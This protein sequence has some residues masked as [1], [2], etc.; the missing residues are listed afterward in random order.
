MGK[1]SRDESRSGR[2]CDKSNRSPDDWK[3]SPFA[4]LGKML[5]NKTDHD[6][7]ET[8]SPSTVRRLPLGQPQEAYSVQQEKLSQERELKRLNDIAASTISHPCEA[9][10]GQASETVSRYVKAE[11]CLKS[12]VTSLAQRAKSLVE[13][14]VQGLAFCERKMPV[15]G[16]NDALVK[17]MHHM[18]EERGNAV[19]LLQSAGLL[20]WVR[21]TDPGMSMAKAWRSDACEI[22]FFSPSWVC[23]KLQWLFLMCGIKLIDVGVRFE[24]TGRERIA[25]QP[26]KPSAGKQGSKPFAENRHEMAVSGQDKEKNPSPV[27]VHVSRRA[28]SSRSHYVSVPAEGKTGELDSYSI[29]LRERCSDS[30]SVQQTNERA[31]LILQDPVKSYKEQSGRTVDQYRKYCEEKS[32]SGSRVSSLAQRAETLAGLRVHG[33]AFRCHEMLVTDWCDAL[34][35]FMQHIGWEYEELVDRMQAAGFLSWI[36]RTDS[37]RSMAEAWRVGAC[38]IRFDT[39][40]HV[41]EKLQWLF[42]MCGMP[43]NDVGM[44]YEG[45]LIVRET[46]RSHSRESRHAEKVVSDNPH[47]LLKSRTATNSVKYSASESSGFY[48][49]VDGVVEY[50]G[51]RNEPS[52][53]VIAR[54]ESSTEDA[55]IG[56]G[57][58]ARDN[59]QFGSI[60]GEDYAD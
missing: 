35:Q 1:F 9:Y 31:T 30:S 33:L 57:H 54:S 50:I 15:S 23:M 47:D 19:N 14:R 32:A 6:A 3:P 55:W 36:V 11:T 45:S 8:G 21:R 2:A 60:S 56:M 7:R 12:G 22:Q 59:G 41:C 48:V 49:L 24:R 51:R 58:F 43:L 26:S 34:A 42:L 27:F 38:T 4:E 20:S 37:A 40:S 44:R 46:R 28:S 16:W 13:L 18:A 17:F 25:R 29:L 10:K 53:R 52:E 39:M 5:F